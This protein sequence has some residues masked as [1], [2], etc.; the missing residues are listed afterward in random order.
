M[1]KKILV[2]YGAD[3]LDLQLKFCRS[4]FRCVVI[5]GKNR[6][7][8]PESENV[9]LIREESIDYLRVALRMRPDCLIIYSQHLRTYL[10]KY[11]PEMFYFLEEQKGKSIGRIKVAGKDHFDSLVSDFMKNGYKI[12]FCSGLFA[13]LEG[14]GMIIVL[15]W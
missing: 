13:I 7:R 6:V 12:T 10:E 5:D 3:F 2:L 11:K 1:E 14:D 4:D 15:E 8:F 9:V